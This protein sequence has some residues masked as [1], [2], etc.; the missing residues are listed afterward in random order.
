[1]AFIRLKCKSNSLYA[2]IYLHFL[3]LLHRVLC[4]PC[5]LLASIGCYYTTA[6]T[7]HSYENR[8]KPRP[9][10]SLS[11]SLSSA[12]QHVGEYAR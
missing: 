9:P 3:W 8:A 11:L 12:R 10:K 4:S 2:V 1:M 6:D 5:C 7:I